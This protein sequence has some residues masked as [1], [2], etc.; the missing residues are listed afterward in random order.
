MYAIFKKGEGRIIKLTQCILVE[1][2]YQA[3]WKCILDSTLTYVKI[4]K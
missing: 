4:K 2:E 3:Q 1:H